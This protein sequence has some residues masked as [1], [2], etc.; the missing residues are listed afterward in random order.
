MRLLARQLSPASSIREP[1]RPPSLSDSNSLAATHRP[2]RSLSL[3]TS[4][5]LSHSRSLFIILFSLSTARGDT[6]LQCHSLGVAS[7]GWPPPQHVANM[8]Y[9]QQWYPVNQAYPGPQMALSSDFSSHG[10]PVYV[11]YSSTGQAGP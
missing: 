11:P 9:G 7:G 5:S 1:P 8:P 3:S 2:G 6:R 4:T 10:G